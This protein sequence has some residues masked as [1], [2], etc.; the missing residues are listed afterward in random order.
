MREVTTRIKQKYR[1]SCKTDKHMFI[2]IEVWPFIW[3][4]ERRWS[5]NRKAQGNQ[6][7]EIGELY[8][9]TYFIPEQR[10][11]RKMKVTGKITEVAR[12]AHECLPIQQ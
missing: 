1:H 5:W 4:T 11:Q 6:W 12:D 7:L 3:T 10:E 8:T 2:Y 9:D